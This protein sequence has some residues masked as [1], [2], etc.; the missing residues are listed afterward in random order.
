MADLVRRMSLLRGL[1][2]RNFA[3]AAFGGG[4]RLHAPAVAAQ[5]SIAKVLVPL[6]HAASVLSAYGAGWSD[7]VHVVQRWRV[8]KLPV[9]SANVEEIFAA[10]ENEAS[11]SSPAR[12]SIQPT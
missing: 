4:G 7:V 6:P 12:A 9:P 2:P 8:L 1:D 11:D 3:C 5:A 10:L